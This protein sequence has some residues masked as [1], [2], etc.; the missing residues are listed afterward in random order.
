MVKELKDRGVR[1]VDNLR[2]KADV[3]KELKKELKGMGYIDMVF[4]NSQ[5]HKNPYI[6]HTSRL[7]A[8]TSLGGCNCLLITCG[9]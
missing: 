1:G 7:R 9:L 3:E 5:S 8:M 4:F 6:T 2:L